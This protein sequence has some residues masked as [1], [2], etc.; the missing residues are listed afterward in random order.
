[1]LN[2]NFLNYKNIFNLKFFSFKKVSFFLFI[3]CLSLQMPEEELFKPYVILSRPTNNSITINIIAETELELYC[4]YGYATNNY[5]GK[6]K[7]YYLQPY[8]CNRIIINNLE[9]NNKYFYRLYYR[10]NGEKTYY[11]MQEAFFNTQKSEGST[12]VFTITSDSHLG[13]KKYCDTKLYLNT[14]SNIAKDKPDFH[15]DLGD[16]FNIVR[17]KKSSLQKIEKQYYEQFKYFSN[18]CDKAPLFI[19]L[20]NCDGELGGE[21]D[22]T[23][24]NIAIVAAQLR[25][26][27]FSNPQPD[28]F[29]SGNNKNEQYIRLREN[30][31]A[32]QWGNALFVVLDPYWYSTSEIADNQLNIDNPKKYN[33]ESINYWNSTIGNEQYKWLKKNLEESNAKFKFVFSHHLLG[34]IRGGIEVAKFYEWGGIDPKGRARFSL[35]RPGW[36]LPIHNL[37]VKNKVTIFFQGHDHLFQK[38]ELDGVIYQ[39]CPMPADPLYSLY[40]CDKYFSGDAFSNSGH[41]RIT[42]YPDKVRVDYIKSVLKKNET[43]SNKNQKLIFAYTVTPK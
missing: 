13:D 25:K 26:A 22:G 40:N 42:V 21:L 5:F 41:L 10:L 3:I 19:A 1:M 16:A 17:Y 34:T 27:Y 9:P 30:Y 23:S 7:I 14:L 31:Y 35:K 4:E 18:V 39:T 28:A 6:T 20:G 32:W 29:Y 24:E 37:F 15:I 12:F 2:I 11:P 33:S 43:I 8:V 38:Q 36:E